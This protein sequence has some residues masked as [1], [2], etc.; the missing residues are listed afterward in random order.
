[1]LETKLLGLVSKTQ[2]KLE[3]IRV[4]IVKVGSKQNNIS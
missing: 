3:T 4:A 1:M 2:I